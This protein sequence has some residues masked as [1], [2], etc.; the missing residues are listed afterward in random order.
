[1]AVGKSCCIVEGFHKG[2]T[3]LRYTVWEKD[4]VQE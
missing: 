1:M 2:D 3:F 4:T